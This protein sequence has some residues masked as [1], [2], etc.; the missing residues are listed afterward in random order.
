MI[1]II[2]YLITLSILHGWLTIYIIEIKIGSNP[3][4]FG[5]ELWNL[6][7]G[8]YETLGKGIFLYERIIGGEKV[9]WCQCS[10]VKVFKIAYIVN[11]WRGILAFLVTGFFFGSLSFFNFENRVPN[12]VQWVPI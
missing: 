9:V 2:I 4:E 12:I 3:I 1:F 7:D 8:N 6:S 10:F 5:W 11:G